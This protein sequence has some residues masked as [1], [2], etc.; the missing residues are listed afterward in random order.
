MASPRA[1]ARKAVADWIRGADISGLDAVLTVYPLR[2]D[3]NQ[4]GGGNPQHQC[5]L[6]VTVMRESEARAALGGEHSGRKRI[7]YDVSLEIFHR[8]TA[9]DPDAALE[10][11]D[12]VIDAV[13]ARLREDRRLGKTEDIVWQAG[14][15]AYGI[16]SDFFVPEG[17]IGGEPIEHYGRI[18]FEVTI[19]ITS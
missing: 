19:W 8:T 16:Q 12:E 18:Q 2:L 10:H 7:D 5:V 17:N 13:K 14:E 11:F 9:P 6:I 3:L 4:L 15:G 1:L